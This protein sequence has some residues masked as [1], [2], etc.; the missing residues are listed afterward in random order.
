MG[1]KTTKETCEGCPAL[2]CSDLEESILRPRTIE[3]VSNL[4]WELHF[5]NTRVFVRNGRWYKLGLGKCMYLNDKNLCSIYEKRPQFCRDHKPPGCEFYGPI[6]DVV[7]GHPE[8]LDRFI[9]KERAKKKRKK[10]RAA[11][12]A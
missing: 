9:R 2:C 10:R 8:G 3:E 7:M 12:S 11:K 4:R 1:T 5:V 6:Y